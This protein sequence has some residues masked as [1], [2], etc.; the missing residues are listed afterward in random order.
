M[1]FEDTT[2][3]ESRFITLEL[4]KFRA[5]IVENVSYDV[6]LAVPKGEF[7]FGNVQAKFDLKELPSKPLPLDFKGLKLTNLS[8]N[9]QDIKN[10]AGQSQTM[11]SEH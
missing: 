5:A 3:E 10:E 2:Y 4:A 7:F 8:I 11:F 6:T 1:L 9:G